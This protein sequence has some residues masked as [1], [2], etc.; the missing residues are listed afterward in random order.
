MKTEFYP[1][2]CCDECNDV[3]H[4]HFDCPVCKHK[5][6]GTSMYGE[7]DSYYTEF[8]CEECEAEFKLLERHEDF[9]F[10][11]EIERAHEN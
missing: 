2:I 5:Y 7:M 11:W 4:N 6:A 1:E 3:I 9:G 10:F 8:S